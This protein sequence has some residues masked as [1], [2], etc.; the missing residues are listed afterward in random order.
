ME[1]YSPGLGGFNERELEGHD[2][3]ERGTGLEWDHLALVLPEV[4]GHSAPS[5][6]DRLL[7]LEQEW[8]SRLGRRC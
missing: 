8:N 3:Q 2:Y 4:K 1:G 6:R 5:Q 7:Q